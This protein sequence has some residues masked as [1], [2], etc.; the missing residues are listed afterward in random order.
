MMGEAVDYPDQTYGELREG[1][2]LAGYS[3]ERAFSR[4]ETLLQSDAWMKVGPGFPDVNI[5]MDSVRLDKFKALA[6]QR[7][8]IVRRIKE[9]QPEV[10]NRQIARTLG[11]GHDTGG[12]FAPDDLKESNETSGPQDADG[13]FAPPRRGFNSAAFNQHNEQWFTPAEYVGLVRAVLGEI[14]LDPASHD[15]AQQ[16]VGASVYFTEADD[17]LSKP[18]SGRVFLNPPYTQPTI[19]HFIDK[20]ID[21]F[22]AKRVT[23]AI[24]L[25]HSFTGSEWFRKAAMA[26]EAVCFTTGRIRF[27]SPEGDLASPAVAQ[28]F[29]YFGD[30]PNRFARTFA[31]VG[32]VFPKPIAARVRRFA[33][34]RQVDKTPGKITGGAA[35]TPS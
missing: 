14:D 8:K 34:V 32:L 2:H 16:T 6:D 35:P 33:D 29:L 7:Q 20:L 1:L 9:L 26:S 31:G 22:A 18:W 17:G 13:A 15:V 11:V 23:A 24:L 4:L 12:A 3:L 10:S 25:T 27:L 21:E 28:A 30:N 19:E 5:F